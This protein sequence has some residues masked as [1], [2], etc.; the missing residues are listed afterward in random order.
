M[1]H[2]IIALTYRVLFTV[3]KEQDFLDKLKHPNRDPIERDIKQ[4]ISHLDPDGILHKHVNRDKGSHTIAITA[5]SIARIVSLN[6]SFFDY[7][8]H[9][10]SH[11]VTTLVKLTPPTSKPDEPA[12]TKLYHIQE[13]Q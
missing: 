5:D 10:Y 12:Y 1:F 13:Y 6:E 11:G 2:T 9:S 3:S 8:S 7:F 4:W